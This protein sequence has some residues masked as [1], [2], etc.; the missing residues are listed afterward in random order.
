MESKLAIIQDINMGLRWTI[1][2][3]LLSSGKKEDVAG[4]SGYLMELM[5][6]NNVNFHKELIGRTI[7]LS[8]DEHGQF[9][10]HINLELI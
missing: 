7:V 1:F 2:T 6:K 10:W 5:E 8:K 9:H 3:V 4:K